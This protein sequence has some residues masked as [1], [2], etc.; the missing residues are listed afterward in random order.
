MSAKAFD[1]FLGVLEEPRAQEL[2]DF[3]GEETIWES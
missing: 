1:E 2:E 3:L